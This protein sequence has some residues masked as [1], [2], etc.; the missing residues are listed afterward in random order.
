MLSLEEEA[1]TKKRQGKKHVNAA[2]PDPRTQN[3]SNKSPT[4]E[5]NNSDEEKDSD[6]LKMTIA[7]KPETPTTHREPTTGAASS[8][9]LTDATV[10]IAAQQ[11]ADINA[12]TFVK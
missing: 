7:D 6:E 1:I 2:R 8:T 10:Q 12:A 4:A 3:Y 11:P 5:S 9:S